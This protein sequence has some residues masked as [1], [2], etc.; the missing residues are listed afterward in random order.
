M[1]LIIAPNPTVDYGQECTRRGLHVMAT[2]TGH[3]VETLTGLGG[4]GAQ[5]MLAFVNG[6][7]LQGH[8]MI[9]LLQVGSE[10]NIDSRYSASIDILLSGESDSA[11]SENELLKLVCDTAA[12]EYAP[13][14][15]VD[16]NIDFQ[17]TRGLLGVSL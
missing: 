16:C 14:R 11:T 13:R 12:G 5:L 8:P 9:P 3:V 17:V 4:T 15:W 10:G 6:E 1:Q 2:P 7:P